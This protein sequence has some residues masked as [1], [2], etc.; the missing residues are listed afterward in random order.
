MIAFLRQLLAAM[1]P[2]IRRAVAAWLIGW[3]AR[4]GRGQM[5]NWFKAFQLAMTALA[6]VGEAM[7]AGSDEGA[8][9]SQA[10]IV[11]IVVRTVVGAAKQYGAEVTN[12]DVDLVA[13]IR[14][15]VE[16]AGLIG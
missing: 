13:V 11:R 9:I 7:G 2:Q 12:S 4:K 16:M 14:D 6:A 5:G 8:N 1:M 15:E 3:A 10:E